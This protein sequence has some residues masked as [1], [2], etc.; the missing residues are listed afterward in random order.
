MVNVNETTCS[1]VMLYSAVTENSMSPAS[2]LLPTIISSGTNTITVDSS[3]ATVTTVNENRVR[4]TPAPYPTTIAANTSSVAGTCTYTNVPKEIKY[5]AITSEGSQITSITLDIVFQDIT[6]TCT[7]L[8]EFEQKYSFIFK[9]STDGRV[10][11]GSPGYHK[12]L[13]VLAGTLATSGTS[14]DTDEEG[15]RLY[16]ADETGECLSNAAASVTPTNYLYHD[17]P[18]LTFGDGAMYG[19][20][21]TFADKAAFDAF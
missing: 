5:T 14:I 17:D 21:K 7:D 2:T 6:G 10:Q 3:A 1:R 19:C 4:V 18:I 11:S 12:G 13:P 9:G 8:L 16:G 20:T 15:F